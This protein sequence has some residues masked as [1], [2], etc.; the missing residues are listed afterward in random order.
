MQVKSKSQDKGSAEKIELQLLASRPSKQ[1]RDPT[2]EEEEPQ[3]SRRESLRQTEPEPQTP[4]TLDSKEEEPRDQT[5]QLEP[6]S[7]AEARSKSVEDL[8]KKP[9]TF[10]FRDSKS[11]D[12]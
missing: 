7:K 8:P 2:T 9:K 12:V 5:A 4:T 10:K 6:S 1:E 11:S 3:H